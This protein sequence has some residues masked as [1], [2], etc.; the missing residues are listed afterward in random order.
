M[1]WTQYGEQNSRCGGAELLLPALALVTVSSSSHDAVAATASPSTQKACFI[2]APPAAALL[3]APSFIH[4]PHCHCCHPIL[5]CRPSR[6][7]HQRCRHCR[8][9]LLLRRSLH[10][11]RQQI[12][13]RARH[14]LRPLRSHRPLRCNRA[15]TR[16]RPD[17]DPKAD[18]RDHRTVPDTYR[19]HTTRHHC[20]LGGTDNQYGNSDRRLCPCSRRDRRSRPHP[21]LAC[22]TT[23]LPHRQALATPN[24][25]ASP[26]ESSTYREGGK[27][28]IAIPESRGAFPVL[29][30]RSGVVVRI[31]GEQVGLGQIQPDE[32]VVRSRQR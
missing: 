18:C 32:R 17:A 24:K 12:L 21:P 20:S 15:G 28:P 26:L 30:E 22:R 14:L 10:Q 2:H 9:L 6:R 4:L 8:W 16:A 29:R 11:L 7:C 31:G 13:L 25:K 23:Q 1:P 19:P 3:P 27:A 5:H